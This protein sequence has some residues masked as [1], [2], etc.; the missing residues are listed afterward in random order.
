MKQKTILKIKNVA[1]ITLAII[2]MILSGNLFIQFSNYL[3]IKVILSFLST[4]LEMIKLYLLIECKFHIKA[5]ER[6]IKF[7]G[8]VE[9]FVYF[10]LAIASLI[11]SLGFVLLSIEE[12]SLQ[13]EEQRQVS[14]FKIEMLV[15]EIEANNRQIQIIQENT[16][17]LAYNA[18]ERNA[19]ANIQIKVIQE[20]NRELIDEV[21]LIRSKQSQGNESQAKMTSADM[22]SLLGRSVGMKGVDVMF[23]LMLV[24]V[25]MLEVALAI[26]SSSIEK[27]KTLQDYKFEL[28][29]YIDALFSGRGQSLLEDTVITNRTGIKLKQCK[30]Y[31][32]ML[33]DMFYN[34]IPL[35]ESKGS[36]TNANFTKE[37]M[38]KIV[39]LRG[40]TEAVERRHK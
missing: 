24:I 18:V 6:L 33:C 1:F 34:N 23:Y 37:Q 20:K 40:G 27:D 3:P 38:K 21:E 5:K 13:F 7:K 35:L 17:D 14:F 16:R 25:V 36:K 32:E 22:F 19:E 39:K 8:V 2:S 15:N 11:A 29:A 10:G 12:Q 28:L 30:I 31:R 26:T 4:A 9:G